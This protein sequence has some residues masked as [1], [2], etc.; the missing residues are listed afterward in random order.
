L[1]RVDPLHGCISTL[2]SRSRRILLTPFGICFGKV[3]IEAAAFEQ[4][5]L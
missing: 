1:F 4:I 5:R 3:D 2:H